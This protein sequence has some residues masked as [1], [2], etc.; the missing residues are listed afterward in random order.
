MCKYTLEIPMDW[1]LYS[2]EGGCAANK[3][4]SDHLASLLAQSLTKEQ[5]GASMAKLLREFEHLGGP[6]TAVREVLGWF[7]DGY[8]ERV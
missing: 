3:A 4:I 5:T 2:R 8:Y 1:A 7:L 6:D